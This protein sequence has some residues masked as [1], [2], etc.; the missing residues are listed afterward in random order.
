MPT[1][2]PAAPSTTVRV[3]ARA[4]FGSGRSRIAR[5][6]LSRA[7]RRLVAQM[8]TSEMTRPVHAPIARLTG[9]I[10]NG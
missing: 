3:R 6:M 4:T 9:S 8:V 7:M 1:T 10:T 5:M 2:T